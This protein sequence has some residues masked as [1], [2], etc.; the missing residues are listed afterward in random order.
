MIK[1]SKNDDLVQQKEREK[2]AANLIIYNISEDCEGDLE[3]HDDEFIS[4]FLETIGVATY[5]KQIVRLGKPNEKKMRPVKLVM[6]NEDEKDTIMS[7]LA[8]LRTADDI[9][10]KLSIREDYTIEE[11]ELIRSYVAQ[12]KKQNEKD[13][14]TEWKVRG[15]PKNGLVVRRIKSRHN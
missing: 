13:N 9:Y 2:R 11:R 15:T 7:R 1:V 10:R 3:T 4:S 8:N 6:E 5:P 12:A 14:T